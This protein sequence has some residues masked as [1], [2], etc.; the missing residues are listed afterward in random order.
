MLTVV[1]CL[2]FKGQL[3]STG[4]IGPLLVMIFTYSYIRCNILSDLAGQPSQED[5]NN[6]VCMF[7]YKT[8]GSKSTKNRLMLNDTQLESVNFKGGCPGQ[9]RPAVSHSGLWLQ[10][11]LC[12]GPG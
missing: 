4:S 7:H 6:V 1:C 10:H 3:S 8:G 5:T 11:C 2:A 9:C 12:S